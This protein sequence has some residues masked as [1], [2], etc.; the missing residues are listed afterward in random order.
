MESLDTEDLWPK[1]KHSFYDIEGTEFL[2]NIK[3]CKNHEKDYSKLAD[4]YFKCAYEI[5]KEVVDSGHNNVKSDMW[6]L[7][8]VYMFRQGMELA[9]KAL[10]CRIINSNNK[11]QEIFH[12][13]K[14]NL[15][16]LFELYKKSEESYLEDVELNWLENYLRSLESI[17]GNSDLF[18]FPF[19]DDFLS[20]Y[21]DQ[22]LDIP[23]MGNNLLQS[24]SLIKKCLEKG[25]NSN[26]IEFDKNRTSEF[27]QFANH[28]IGNCYLWDSI[29]S[30]GFHKQVVG[31]SKAAE[32]LFCKCDHI[33]NEEKVYPLLFLHR[34]LIEL[35]LKRMFYKSIEYRVPK[36][37][38]YSKRKSHLLYKELWKNVRPMIQYYANSRGQDVSVINIVE[39][40][41]KELSSIDKNGDMFRY[42]ASYSFEY[43]FNDK[44]I[45]LK[46]V[47]KYMQAIFNFLDG[48]DYEFSYIE[49]YEAECRDE[50]AQYQDCW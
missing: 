34:N 41:L 21:R 28:G 35:G 10:I 26:I 39:K 37:I 7:P 19:N 17:D 22:F 24:Y 46:N 38:F 9:I 31:Y 20:Q 12:S 15:Y 5:C 40:Q 33:S 18:R 3:W 8:S 49:D 11:I 48:C 13:C 43:K 47:Y 36:H 44:D 45:D 16:K 30:D 1:E 42:P 50:M 6:F 4:S 23:H 14:H 29:A 2:V 25:N 32:F 27:L